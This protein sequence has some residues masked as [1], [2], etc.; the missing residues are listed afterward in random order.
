MKKTTILKIFG[1][2]M[3]VSIVLFVLGLFFSYLRDDIWSPA[4]DERSV[5]EVKTY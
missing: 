5:P 3:F 1:A 2:A 4:A